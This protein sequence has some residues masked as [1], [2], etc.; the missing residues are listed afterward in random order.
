MALKNT[1]SENR[2]HMI[3][4]ITDGQPTIGEQK[5]DVLVSKI[6][7]ANTKNIRIFSMGIGYD[8]NAHLLDRF[9]EETNSY[10]TY[11]TP[12]EDIEIKVSNFYTK[13]NSP[14]MTDISVE[15]S[16]SSGI[17]EIYPKS[18]PDLFKGNSLTIFG[19][20]KTT[21]ERKAIVK[22]KINTV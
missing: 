13:V 6:K 3:V 1:T 21:A 11:I 16:P 4:F 5:D 8:V 7:A 14:V 9:T 17:E 20:F 19:R 15:Y 22:G 2:P 12:K 10:S 18:I